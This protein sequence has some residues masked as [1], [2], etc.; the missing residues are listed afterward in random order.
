MPKRARGKSRVHM[1]RVSASAPPLPSALPMPAAAPIM[2]AR[3]LRSPGREPTPT[4]VAPRTDYSYVTR[5]LIHIGVLA[6][7]LLG[8]MGLLALVID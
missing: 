1:P 3:G 5:D 4:V 6:V 7:L 2:E 8:V